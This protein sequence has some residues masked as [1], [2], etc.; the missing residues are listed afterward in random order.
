M[1]KKDS[2]SLSGSGLLQ[3][4]Q[5]SG[6]EG[7][8][9]EQEVPGLP[10]VGQASCGRWKAP[11]LPLSHPMT[12]A[13]SFS[14]AWGSP[15]LPHLV[16]FGIYEVCQ[17]PRPWDNYIPG[18]TLGKHPPSLSQYTPAAWRWRQGH[19]WDL[20]AAVNNYKREIIEK[21]TEERS[22]RQATFWKGRGEDSWST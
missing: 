7:G 8:E 16:D 20:S 11:K 10:G 12:P 21:L 13:T 9:R 6:C 19:R 14:P 15:P 17:L 2:R 22:Q 18:P 3:P 1:K 4:G 5:S